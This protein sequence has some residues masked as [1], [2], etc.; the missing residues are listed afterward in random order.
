MEELAPELPG[1]HF[2]GDK[3]LISGA[4]PS[5]GSGQTTSRDYTM[6]VRMVGQGL[7]PGMQNRSEA[8]F[9][10]KE[11]LISGKFQQGFG[12]S[13][14]EQAVEFPLILKKNRAQFVRHGENDVEV[15]DIEQ[16]VFLI[17]DPTLF[18][19]R[20]ALRAMPVSAGVV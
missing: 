20:L 2:D 8:D 9:S 16:I 17:I 1:Q 11:L 18:G 3:E 6:D 12:S 7:A 5:A 14:E 15:W 19:K 10:A 13:T 4:G